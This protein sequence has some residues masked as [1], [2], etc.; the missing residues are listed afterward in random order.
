MHNIKP[1]FRWPGGKY[2]E[3]PNFQ[4]YF[5]KNINNY[6]EPFVGGGAVFLN[7]EA[8]QYY[9]N[10]K[11]E[12]L[13]NLYKAIKYS[14][15]D[16]IFTLESII[17]EWNTFNSF[18]PLKIINKYISSYELLNNDEE[19]L[20]KKMQQYFKNKCINEKLSFFLIQSLVFYI[21]KSFKKKYEFSFSYYESAIK[22]GYYSYIRF[23]FNTEHKIYF[24]SAYYYFVLQYCFG[25][26]SRFNNNGD[27]NIPYSGSYNNKKIDTAIF[28]QKNVLSKFKKTKISNLDYTIFF[29]QFIEQSNSDDF[30]FLDPPYDCMFNNYDSNP[31]LKEQQQILS[32]Y[33]INHTKCKWMLVISETSLI[34]ELYLNQKN[35]Y[36]T[37]YQKKY[38]VNIQK[39]NNQI[40]THL[41][42]SNYPLF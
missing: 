8:K 14:K 42:I 31:F 12:D 11:S 34:K 24:R 41:I 27:F 29:E 26:L 36:I 39:R 9:I 21:K 1:F 37:K 19:I 32:N 2:H 15:D 23:L 16:F 30:I 13:V 22:S 5:P 40:A 17:Y 20:K 28:L 4:Q 7:T 6:Y 33:L 38:K 35:I 3:L 18:I 25:G 10:D